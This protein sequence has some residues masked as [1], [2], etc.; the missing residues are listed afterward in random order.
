[1]TTLPKLIERPEPRSSA[2]GA[3]AFRSKVIERHRKHVNRGM[4]RLSE[5]MGTHV[6]VRSAGNYVFDERDE[7]Y[8]D[9]G[10]Y[11]V[12]TLGHCHPAVVK[13]VTEQ[14]GRLPLST[15]SL[16]N[17]E[18]AAAAE[19]LSAVTPAGLDYVYFGSSGTEATEAAIK[20]AC[21]NGRTS[22]IST[23]GGYHGKTLGALSVTGRHSYRQ[24]FGA[25]LAPAEFVRFGDADELAAALARTGATGCVILEPVQA[26]GG[27]VIP[28]DGYLR[29]VERL[30]RHYGAYLILDEI[31]TGLARLGDWWGLDREN[32]VPDLLL[33]GKALSGGIVP[34]SALVASNAAFEKLNQAPILHTS[35]FSG[36]PL[37]A[38]AA[39]AAVE[40]MRDED[41]VPRARALGE[42]LLGQLGFLRGPRCSRLVRDVRGR[43][44]LIGIEFNAEFLAGD[45]MIE[46]LKR[47]V[48]VSYSLN[49]HR[50]VRLTPSAFLAESDVKWLLAAMRE[51]L[52]VLDE[53]Y[54]NFA[55]TFAGEQE[56]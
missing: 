55:A 6:E 56:I 47:N 41:V 13:A 25:L 32:V 15:R 44:I 42:T 3:E 22:L 49:A 52:A 30:C 45:F 27:V 11:G 34:V 7:R 1:M 26:E 31:Q 24:P 9:C 2:Q 19:A 35:T 29:E 18:V 36:N 48:V 51:S 28:P 10:G 23:H 21:L 37:A 4:A 53:R 12:F 39:R 8:L 46:M 16:V 43:G 50:V 40:T 20:L 14:L 54:P 5:L 38:A 33:V 17:P